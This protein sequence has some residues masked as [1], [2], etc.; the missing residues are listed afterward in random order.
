VRDLLF[1]QTVLFV[2]EGI[3][4]YKK[5]IVVLGIQ[6]LTSHSIEHIPK[7]KAVLL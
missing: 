2:K 4:F 1:E 6:Y 7:P 3:S 5:E